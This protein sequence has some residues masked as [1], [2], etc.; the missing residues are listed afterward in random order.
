ME[1]GMEF[2]VMF[3]FVFDSNDGYC[4]LV[5]EYESILSIHEMS[6]KKSRI[7]LPFHE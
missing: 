1:V 4:G 5:V 3:G 6:V 7:I 2:D